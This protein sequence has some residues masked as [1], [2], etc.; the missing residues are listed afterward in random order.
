MKWSAL[1]A[2]LVL[3]VAVP[4]TAK[5]IKGPY[6]Q[7]LTTSSVTIMVH[8]D[9]ED[10]RI[11]WGT[12]PSMDTTW[13]FNEHDEW[14]DGYFR[15]HDLDEE[16]L[17][18]TNDADFYEIT[19]SGLVAG[20]KY[21]Y[22]VVNEEE[23]FG[24]PEEETLVLEFSTPPDPPSYP[25]VFGVIGDCKAKGDLFSSS[26]VTNQKITNMLVAQKP[27][28]VLE[29]GDMTGDADT[30]GDWQ[31]LFDIR[32]KLFQDAPFY[33]SMGNH[34]NDDNGKNY[35]IHFSLPRT[36]LTGAG[37]YAVS[38]AGKADET[39]LFYSF[40]FQGVHFLAVNTEFTLNPGSDQHTFIEEDLSKHPCTPKIAYYHVPTFT[41]G[42]K[43]DSQYLID[44]LHPLFVK[45]GLDIVFQGHDHNYQRMDTS[46]TDG[47]LY[48]V[49]G[50][51]G[52]SLD[53]LDLSGANLAKGIQDNHYILMQ[54]DGAKFT[55]KVYLNTGDLFDTFEVDPFADV[56]DFCKPVEPEPQPEPQ[57]EPVPEP[58]PEPVPE[59]APEPVPETAPETAPE[60][61]EDAVVSVEDP[62][63]PGEDDPSQ[64]T[65]PEISKPVVE[66]LP[67]DPGGKTGGSGCSMQT[68]MVKGF[69]WLLLLGATLLVTGFRRE[70]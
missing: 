22:Q 54:Y 48:V 9:R 16:T 49:T 36:P 34:D 10:I 37:D 19:L 3:L 25:F 32:T 21:Y 69:P 38:D 56:P 52:A 8:S 51:G 59:P 35:Q 60:P 43:D 14:V 67:G 64:G 45:H 27:E 53:V 11:R 40:D 58:I 65:G 30:Y 12:T 13:Y 23:G 42:E 39:E 66:F 61:A 50:G 6:L 68:G 2:V 29:T 41:Y 4:A 15:V 63:N 46:A 24:S 1:L 20:M 47:I 57:P 18:G 33:P 5:F 28:L 55:G 44:N 17:F 26:N 62:G 31:K 70:T 7:N